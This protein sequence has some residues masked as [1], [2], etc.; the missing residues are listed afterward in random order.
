MDDFGHDD[1]PNRACLDQHVNSFAS[2]SERAAITKH[3]HSYERVAA[4]D[5]FGLRASPV[6]FSPEEQKKQMALYPDTTMPSTG[7]PIAQGVIIG[8]REIEVD[9]VPLL[10]MQTATTLGRSGAFTIV[11][12]PSLTEAFC[13]AFERSNIY[14]VYDGQTGQHIFYAKERSECFWRVCC[15]PRHTLFMEFKSSANVPPQLLFMADI[16]QLPTAMTMEREGCPS[17][18]C[19]GCCVLTPACADGMYLHAGA[20]PPNTPNTLKAANPACVGFAAQPRFGGGLAPSVNVMER[21]RGGGPGNNWNTLAKVE[22]PQCFGGCLELCFGSTFTV[23]SMGH[24]QMDSKLGHGD[25]ATITKQKPRDFAG[26][27]REAV[28]DADIYTMT[29]NPIARLAPQQK[30]SLL[31]TL[32]L[33]DFMFFEN[34]NAACSGNGCN[35]CQCYCCGLVCPCMCYVPRNGGG[36]GGGGG[37]FRADQ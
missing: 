25:I 23:S 20:I 2:A 12:R 8:E 18:P 37:G 19:L 3:S 32:I 1:L 13:P 17:K 4:N 14:D 15:A 26:V 31:G 28:T 35:L 11:Q 36:G 29:L 5:E 7:I 24:S 33:T 21:A 10:D 30:A 9:A 27:L 16:D 34:D 6:D 22:G